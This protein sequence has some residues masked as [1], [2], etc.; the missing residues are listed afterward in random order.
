M[1]EYIAILMENDV[2]LLKIFKDFKNGKID[3]FIPKK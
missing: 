3:S 1:K 2:N